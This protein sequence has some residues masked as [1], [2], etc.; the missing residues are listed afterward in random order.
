MVVVVDI[1]DVDVDVEGEVDVVV[2]V[3]VCCRQFIREHR[4]SQAKQGESEWM[5]V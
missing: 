5:R 3:V 1:V 4:Q 2:A